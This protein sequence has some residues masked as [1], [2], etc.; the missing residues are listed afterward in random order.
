ME[1]TRQDLLDQAKAP[2]IQP[3]PSPPHC[4]PSQ[5]HKLGADLSR[6]P[7]FSP[8]GTAAL[9]VSTRAGLAASLMDLSGMTCGC[10]PSISLRDLGVPVSAFSFLS[11][12]HII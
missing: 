4:Y 1:K 10:Q 6:C 7:S 5:G 9:R 12:W 11:S 3:H 2:R 8:Q